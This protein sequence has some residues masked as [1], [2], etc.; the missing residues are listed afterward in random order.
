MKS[1]DLFRAFVEREL[2]TSLESLQP[3]PL[4]GDEAV[5]ALWPLND[6]FRPH[7]ARISSL[8]YDPSFELEADDAI[9]LLARDSTASWESLSSG[10]WRVLLERQQQG[11]LVAQM[12]AAAGNAVMPVP[13]GL[14]S[15]QKT[16]VVTLFLLHSMKLPFPPE[17]RSGTEL[18]Q[19][20][21]VAPPR[22][23]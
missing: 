7:F 11:I 16:V 20:H 14:S 6:R 19:G 13:P 15:T 5:E 9:A 1:M 3:Q 2:G 10:A 12:N 23:H 18:P 8:Q 21:A 4:S 17:D 22:L